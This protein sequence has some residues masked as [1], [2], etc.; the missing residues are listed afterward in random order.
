MEHAVELCDRLYKLGFYFVDV[1]S[2]ILNNEKHQT[3]KVSVDMIY[4]DLTQS[5][6]TSMQ[7]KQGLKSD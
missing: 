1:R 6:C 2:S 4:F 3:Y 5:G 7:L